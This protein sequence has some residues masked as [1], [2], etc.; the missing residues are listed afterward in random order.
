MEVFGLSVLVLMENAG[1]GCTDWLLNDGVEGRVVIC[2]G[3]G[4]NGGD[5]L[6]IARHLEAAGVETPRWCC[7]RNRMNCREMRKPT[8]PC[9][10]RRERRSPALPISMRR[11]T[12]RKFKSPGIMPPPGSSSV[13]TRLIARDIPTPLHLSERS[14]P[15]CF[16]ARFS[17]CK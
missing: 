4:N 14:Q 5:G 13:A 9:W 8:S 7:S 11:R 2:C 12:V 3:K 15:Q 10:R 17:Y 6:V 16:R 1:R